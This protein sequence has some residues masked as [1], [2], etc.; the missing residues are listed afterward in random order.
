MSPVKPARSRQPP[1]AI[2]FDLDGTL[3]DTFALII[4]AWNEAMR[5]PLGREFT[6]EEVMSRFGI[7]DPAMI[8]REL[9]VAHHEQAVET[10]HRCYES[11]HA[12]LAKSFDGIPEL[13]RELKRRRVPMAVVTGK[14]E[15][16]MSATLRLLGLREYFG[17]NISGEDVPR[18]KPA[19]DGLIEAA[20]R[21]GVQPAHCAFVGDSPVDI[22]AGR[23]AGAVTV[24]AG[25]H[26][27]YRDKVR[28]LEPDLWADTPD[29]VLAL[30][31]RAST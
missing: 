27:V 1:A 6:T 13:L 28:A 7:P 25:W 18:Q 10:Y 14:G 11:R 3:A 15:R 17:A 21:L 31:D 26:A 5:E 4:A 29:Q 2:V 8:R 23:A 24:A 20:R 19:P 12:E 22:Q 16:S 9:P 30:F